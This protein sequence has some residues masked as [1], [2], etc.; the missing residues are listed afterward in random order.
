MT[1]SIYSTTEK[2]TPY[3]FTKGTINSDVLDQDKY[4]YDRKGNLYEINFMNK[5]HAIGAMRKLF[6]AF[7][8]PVLHSRC[9]IA[10]MKQAMK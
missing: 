9:Y 1:V 10:L 3:N 8:A 6:E 5:F 7:G 2:N 4:W